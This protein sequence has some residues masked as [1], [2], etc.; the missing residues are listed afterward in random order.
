MEQAVLEPAVVVPEL[1]GEGSV[2]VVELHLPNFADT[3]RHLV[4]VGRRLVADAQGA[5]TSICIFSP[6]TNTA[7]SLVYITT[8]SA[9]EVPN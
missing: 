2:V 9:L 6:T 5:Q 7:A 4:D 1:E 3:A 8:S